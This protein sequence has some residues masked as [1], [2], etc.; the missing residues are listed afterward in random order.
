MATVKLALALEVKGLINIQY[1]IKGG[2][3]TC[4]RSTPAPAAPSLTSARRSACSLARLA[5][6]IMIGKT[7]DQ[8]GFTEEKQFNHISI[9]ESVLP[10]SSSRSGHLLGPEMKS[11]GEV[12]GL[13]RSF[14]ISYAKAQMS[15]GNSLP[16]EGASGGEPGG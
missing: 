14:G 16:V 9:K 5:A 12:I 15:A 11:T 8:L 6:K 3:S 7:L 13:D 4:W 1:A 10:F 2:T